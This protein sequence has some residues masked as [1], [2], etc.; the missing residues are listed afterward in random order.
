MG[1]FV[2]FGDYSYIQDFEIVF[3]LGIARR[4]DIRTSLKHGREHP[5]ATVCLAGNVTR[6]VGRV[7]TVPSGR[8]TLRGALGYHVL[9]SWTYPAS[10]RRILLRGGV[11]YRAFFF[12]GSSSLEPVGRQ[13]VAAVPFDF[14]RSTAMQISINR[15]R[16]A[17]ARSYRFMRK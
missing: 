4:I 6:T 5:I 9:F 10:S 11:S 1:I 7:L 14:G 2:R 3:E 8:D 16:V 12:E 15:L 17:A 13:H